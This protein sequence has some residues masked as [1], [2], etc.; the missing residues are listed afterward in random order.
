MSA[1]DRFISAAASWSGWI[2]RQAARGTP[3]GLAER[4]EEE[5]LAD[6]AVQSSVL[7]RLCFALGCCWAALVI[8]RDQGVPLGLSGKELALGLPRRT[9][10]LLLVVCVHLGAIYLLSVGLTFPRSADARAPHV[11]SLQ[12]IGICTGDAAPGSGAVMPS[13]ACGE[14]L[15]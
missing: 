14:P 5:W 3:P 11:G 13:M 10:A 7:T 1:G 8:A 6:L 9:G 4:L 2:I 12:I 15:R